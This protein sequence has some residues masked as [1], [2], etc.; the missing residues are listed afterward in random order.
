LETDEWEDFPE[1]LRIPIDMHNKDREDGA[2]DDSR[3]HTD[4][5][6][7]PILDI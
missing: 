7:V 2:D 1:K 3:P 5:S 4:E 6:K